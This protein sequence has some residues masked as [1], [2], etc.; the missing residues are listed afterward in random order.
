M[1][2]PDEDVDEPVNSFLRP[3]ML[4]LQAGHLLPQGLI[5]CFMQGRLE[6]VLLLPLHPRKGSQQPGD[7]V[8]V[9]LYVLSLQGGHVVPSRLT[10]LQELLLAMQEAQCWHSGSSTLA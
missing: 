3:G 8:L 9:K 6:S 2:Q 5:P 10:V 1:C 7:A 4:L